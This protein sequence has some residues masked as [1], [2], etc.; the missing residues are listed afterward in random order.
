MLDIERFLVQKRCTH[1]H[2]DENGRLFHHHHSHNEHHKLE[3]LFAQKLK[4]TRKN[5]L[6]AQR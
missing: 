2:Q 1:Q 4:D 3:E 5:M 6:D